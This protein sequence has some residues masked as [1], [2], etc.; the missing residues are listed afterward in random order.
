MATKKRGPSRKDL[1]REAEAAEAREREEDSDELEDDE[2]EDED[3]EEDE[4]DDDSD[5]DGDEDDRPKKKKKK[6]VEKKPVVKKPA[7]KRTRTPKEVRMKAVWV[8]FDNA[9]KRVGVY[10]YSEKKQAEKLLAQK[11]EEKKTTFYI[12]LV[13]EPLEVAEPAAKP[14]GRASKK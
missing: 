2:A 9:S 1:R 6:V 13:K 4:D 8:V 14:A 7:A 11:I 5:D 3:E 10:P 12:Q